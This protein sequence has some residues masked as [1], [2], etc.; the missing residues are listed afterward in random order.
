MKYPLIVLLLLSFHLVIGQER[1]STEEGLTAKFS[2]NKVSDRL[3]G[4]GEF[5]HFRNNFEIVQQN[6]LKLEA[7]VGL[8][9]RYDFMSATR[10][11]HYSYGAR[12]D[13]QVAPKSLFY[14]SAQYIS[15]PFDQVDLQSTTPIDPFFPN[16]E[17]GFGLDFQ[18]NNNINLDIGNK[19]LLPG[20]NN[21]V[22]NPTPL[23]I[24]RAKIKI[25]F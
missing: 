25:G 1:N 10:T 15:E 7:F 16:S 5:S 22:F 21:A 14:I 4:V 13:M 9:E 6:F 23:N 11:L 2:Q 18:I 17:I 3:F 24:T 20:D 8:L 19:T 12:L